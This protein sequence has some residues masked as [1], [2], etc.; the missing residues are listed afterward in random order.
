MIDPDNTPPVADHELLARFILT[1][2]EMR[3]DGTVKPKLY[4]PYSSV[5]L[6]SIF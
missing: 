3:A 5:E 1:S 6:S 4:L 2:N